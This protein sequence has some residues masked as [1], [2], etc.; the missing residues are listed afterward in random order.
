VLAVD[1]YYR[2]LG[3]PR[4]RAL[5]DVLADWPSACG[6][7]GWEAVDRTVPVLAAA[8]EANV[9]VIYFHSTPPELGGW[10]RKPSGRLAPRPE[11]RDPNA[12]VDEVAP[13]PGD[14][15]LTKIGPS[16]FHQTPLDTVLRN[17]GV[18]TVLV[19]GESTSGCVRATVADACTGGYRAGVIGDCCFDRFEASHWVNLFDLNQKYGDVITSEETIK[20]L[21]TANTETGTS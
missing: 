11:G 16:G 12:I 14:I 5:E 18:D 7:Q 2:A 19:C 17:R 3:Y 1:L 10:N 15:V 9:P 4:D 6:P 13:A 8:R 20:Y 21:R